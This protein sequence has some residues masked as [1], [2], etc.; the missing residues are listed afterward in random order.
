MEKMKKQKKLVMAGISVVLLI[1]VAVGIYIGAGSW[2]RKLSSFLDL[3]QKYLEDMVYEDA[4]LVFDEAIAIDP[5]CAE[6]YLG[7]AQAQYALGYLE[8]AV[9]TLQQGI[10]Q[11][12]DGTELE[13]FLQ[14]ILD[15]LSDASA[16][17]IG[18]EIVEVEEGMVEM[19]EPFRGPL[20]LNYASI[21]RKI[22]A[23]ESDIQLEVLDGDT[24]ENYIWESSNP[25]C[26]AV[27]ETG[28]LTCFPV[29]GSAEIRVKD[30]EGRGDFCRVQIVDSSDIEDSVE[31]RM[32]VEDGKDRLNVL[33]IGEENHK[34]IQ[35][36]G[37]S[38]IGGYVYHSGDVSIPE[39]LVYKG[40]AIPVTLISSY[41]Y[42]WC[43]TMESIK[44][45]A[46]VKI[47]T[48]ESFMGYNP[49]YYCTELKK[50]DVDVNNS[51][52]KSVDGV[53]YSKDGKTLFSYPAA[54][55]GTTFTIPD[56]VEEVCLGAFVGCRNLEK[57]LVGEG[58]AFYKSID[59]VLV[60]K[61]NR[62]VAYPIGRKMTSYTVPEEITEIMENAFYMSELKEVVCK[63]LE[64]ITS[65]SFRQCTK[66]EK[67]EGGSATKYIHLSEAQLKNQR[68]VELAGIDEMCNLVTLSMNCF[69]Y[70]TDN[71]RTENLA[72]LG[73]LDS[74]L[75]LELLGIQ[76]SSGLSWLKKLKK[77]KNLAIGG[78]ISE[79]IL[80][81]LKDL[82][83]LETIE[84]ASVES[85]SDIS[86]VENLTALKRFEIRAETIEMNDFSELFE[87]PGLQYV[88]IINYSESD[89]LIEWFEN[90]RTQKPNINIRYSEW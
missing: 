46:S 44:I 80:F 59:G 11:V 83:D 55:G 22:D 34:E 48:E 63:S 88:D 18:E 76:D 15:E 61:E 47:M 60:D 51:Q 53:L 50:I 90:I 75:T 23:L 27:S 74:L 67:I 25:E 77:L 14:Q 89:G 85:L 81:D 5:K 24:P 20:L 45:P 40:E 6:A 9:D 65:E 57:I 13:A 10:E 2:Q 64:S 1:V 84:L 73:K 30:T 17:E 36:R 70:E 54:K 58:N 7:K 31:F 32:E 56:E 49:F 87:L 66:L 69:D 29:V 26:A 4:I 79:E 39:K 42:D 3:G 71:I 41:A 21:V 33:V 28:L 37:E 82:S 86:W 68:V 19:E 78:A 12:D 16:E 35:I 43:N 8:E 72:E 52:I 38:R 62:L